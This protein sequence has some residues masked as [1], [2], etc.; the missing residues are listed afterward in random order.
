MEMNDQSSAGSIYNPSSRAIS[1]EA[2][3]R[4]A[5][6]SSD[7][8]VQSLPVEKSIKSP[9]SPL[10]T[11]VH[12]STSA[13]MKISTPNTL[14]VQ[15]YNNLGQSLPNLILGSPNNGTMS[16]YPTLHTLVVPNSRHHNQHLLSPSQRGIS[17]PPPSP[18]RGNLRRGIAIPQSKNPPLLKTRHIHSVSGTNAPSLEPMNSDELDVPLIS[19]YYLFCSFIFK[20]KIIF[21][22]RRDKKMLDFFCK[23]S[24]I[25]YQ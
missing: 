8:G 3:Q 6:I 23:Y 11:R 7:E 5:S 14:S 24:S 12:S 4:T 16:T 9:K 25:R 21:K 2:D 19:G 17:Y 13:Q 22:C 15:P 10:K 18:T 1:V 20:I